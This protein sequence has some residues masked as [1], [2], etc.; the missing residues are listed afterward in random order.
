MQ[1]TPTEAYQLAKLERMQ[2]FAEALSCRRKALLNYFGEHLFEDCGNCD[3]CTSPP[4]YFDGT[5][6]A[7]KV[8]S[9]IYR[10]KGTE[11]LGMVLDVLRG[12]K[13]AAVFDKG[14]QQIKTYGAASDV[15][16]R[17]LQQYIIQMLN[18][19][20]LEIRFHEKGRLLLTPLA[21]K[22]LFEAR[23]VQ[24]AHIVQA[25]EK[26]AS[27]AEISKPAETNLF[28]KL[29]V[30]RAVLAKDMGVP[31]YVVFSDASLKDMED[32]MPASEEEF[33]TILGVGQAKLEKYAAPFLKVIS[34][35]TGSKAKTVSKK[36]NAKKK[37]GNTH[38]ETL[39]LYEEGLSISEMAAERNL[40]ETTIIS[41][42]SYLFQ[43]VDSVDLNRFI[44]SE[45]K[46]AI[47]KAKETLMEDQGLKAYFEFFEGKMPYWK[48][49]F[50]LSILESEA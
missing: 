35:Y 32:K 45:E 25:D 11:P 48:I 29:K 16:W 21:E 33:A 17:D 41:H 9:A 13:N 26:K 1:G 42:L 19:G 10:L 46:E 27:A 28:E 49:K 3:I 40:K 6:L 34:V 12:A 47:Q 37:K 31:A 24:L 36:R 5:L 4:E 22:I 30:L 2:Q 8:C 18:Q 38:K 43:S 7:Q 23:K 44:S 15:S 50:G 20:I 14:Y 39:K